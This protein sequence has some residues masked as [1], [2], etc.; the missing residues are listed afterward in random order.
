MFF[1]V[2]KFIYIG[3]GPREEEENFQEFTNLA[4]NLKVKGIGEEES[5][6]GIYIAL[7]VSNLGRV[8]CL[9]VSLS[10]CQLGYQALLTMCLCLFVSLLVCLSLCISATLS[11]CISFPLPSISQSLCLSFSLSSVFLSLSI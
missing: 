4:K 11:L 3:E 7:R 9:S 6:G 10:L 2:L 1:S 8:Y 5:F